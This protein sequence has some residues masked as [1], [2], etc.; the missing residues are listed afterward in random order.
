MAL[1]GRKP[2]L[3]PTET[4]TLP[5]GAG[6]QTAIIARDSRHAMIVDESEL[7][8]MREL[9]GSSVREIACRIWKQGAMPLTA[10]GRLLGDLDRNGFLSSGALP[11]LDE[12]RRDTRY[13]RLL[14]KRGK[15]PAVEAMPA[16]SAMAAAG[17]FLASPA[18]L[19]LCVLVMAA[20]CFVWRYRPADSMFLVIGDSTALGAVF[21]LVTAFTVSWLS[22]WL[23][24]LALAAA[25]GFRIPL[26]VESTAGAPLPWLDLTPV[27]AESK[28]VRICTTAVAPVMML[29]LG[30]AGYLL[31]RGLM[32][33]ALA[34]DIALQIAL[35]SWISFLLYTSP[36][37]FS[38]LSHF[39]VVYLRRS[40]PARLASDAAY[41]LIHSLFGSSKAGPEEH[42]GLWGLWVVAWPLLALRLLSLIF[43]R[44]LPVLTNMLAEE[45]GTPAFWGLLIL[46]A[47]LAGGILFAVLST[48][49]LFVSGIDRMVRRRF[50]P[51]WA[52]MLIL[53]GVIGALAVLWHVDQPDAFQASMIAPG[54]RVL[55]AIAAS[56]AIWKTIRKDM[57]SLDA[58]A[59]TALSIVIASHI[60]GGSAGQGAAMVSSV[61]EYASS[62]AAWIAGSSC[63][64]A[65][66]SLLVLTALF[67]LEERGSIWGGSALI[68]GI[69]GGI[70]GS[71][72]PGPVFSHI[73]AGFSFGVLFVRAIASLPGRDRPAWLWLLASAVLN[74]AGGCLIVRSEWT[75]MGEF[76]CQASLVMMIAAIIARAAARSYYWS[77]PQTGADREPYALLG[78]E[79]RALVGLAHPAVAPGAEF[80]V[81]ARKAER[82]L[83]T[84]TWR[85][86]LVHWIPD[87][88]WKDAVELLGKAHPVDSLAPDMSEWDDG[89]VGQA[90]ARVPC[91]RECG[92]DPKLLGASARMLVARPGDVLIRQ[93]VRDDALFAIVKGRVA[94]ELE[95][96]GIRVTRLAVLEEGA[97]VGEISFMTGRPRTATVRAVESLTAIVLRRCDV[98][99]AWPEASRHIHQAAADRA[100][101]RQIRGFPVFNEMPE[102]LFLR[103]ILQGETH[104]LESGEK[105]PEHIAGERPVIAVLEGEVRAGGI[106]VGAGGLDGIGDLWQPDLEAAGIEAAAASRVVTIPR[107]LMREAVDEIVLDAAQPA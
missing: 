27:L 89:R 96:S 18:A 72:I 57:W 3:I 14:A 39:M 62:S 86:I 68:A 71:S 84:D 22:V 49:W 16:N 56:I 78:D 19:A 73:P 33:S 34:P 50:W 55:L 81:I 7:A 92:I 66:V 59:M 97:Y 30:S 37:W 88:T 67:V 105:L 77:D 95:E 42:G 2:Q 75:G 36:W 82:C 76:V 98:D 100:W 23:Q 64:W 5:D 90:L 58:A 101:S 15:A 103:T 91:L 20:A 38:P 79:I 12:S 102:S 45:A 52:N 13:S 26:S 69:V 46:A 29:T 43:R 63:G 32:D 93:G 107:A 74:G 94:I 21:A 85:S 83:G 9:D 40:S 6:G 54:V 47:V 8:C 104:S 60:V 4:K 31:C 51:E 61:N 106:H 87:L 17:R 35:G 28:R 65:A 44:N 11:A 41:G 10:L 25:V 99:A 53:V 70:I 80:A 1:E 48:A 24:S